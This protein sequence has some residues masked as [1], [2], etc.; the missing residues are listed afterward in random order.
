MKTD[1]EK[2]PKKTRNYEDHWENNCNWLYFNKLHYG[3][4]CI[5]FKVFLKKLSQYAT[6]ANGIFNTAPFITY[7]KASGKTSKLRKH[8]HHLS[9]EKLC[10]QGLHM[11]IHVVVISEN[12]KNIKTENLSVLLLKFCYLLAKEEIPLTTKFELLLKQ[13]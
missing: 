8:A 9:M 7:Q 6:K 13:F 12:E 10:M 5:I 4:F 1:V 3:A 11:P 2:T